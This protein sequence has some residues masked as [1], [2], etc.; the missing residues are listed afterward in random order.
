M[1]A[2]T[3]MAYK[4]IRSNCIKEGGFHDL[5]CKKQTCNSNIV[6]SNMTVLTENILN[7]HKDLRTPCFSRDFASTSA[8]WKKKKGKLTFIKLLHNY[9]HVKKLIILV[10]RI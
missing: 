2:D 7:K 9:I 1:P 4:K 3:L 8:P 10:L 6:C 5:D